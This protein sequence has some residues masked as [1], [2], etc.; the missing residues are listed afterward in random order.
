V[1]GER[2]STGNHPHQPGRINMGRTLVY[3]LVLMLFLNIVL[4]LP[5]GTLAWTRG[6]LFLVVFLVPAAVSAVWVWRVNPEIFAARSRFH[7]GTKGWDHILLTVLVPVMVLIFPVAALDDGRYHW[8]PVP[9]WVCGIGYVLTLAGMAIGAWAQAVNKFF[10]PGVRIQTDRGHKVIDSGHYAIVRHP[11]YVSACFFFVGIALS[12]GSFWALI[13]AVFSCVILV[14][15]T[16]WEDGTLQ[17]ELPGYE[18]H[19][20]RVRSK[21]VPG[22]W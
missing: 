12:L 6:W 3:V 1:S 13:P 22:V 9:W 21:L 4:L 19:S 14:V 18:E 17:D 2:T 7:E 8:H 11:G 16:I 15:R 20:Q 5:A 10:E